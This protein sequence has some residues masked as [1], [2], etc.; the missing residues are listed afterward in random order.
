[1]KQYDKKEIKEADAKQQDVKIIEKKDSK[2]KK[3]LEDRI[4]KKA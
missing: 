1:M 4:I 2:K 3:D